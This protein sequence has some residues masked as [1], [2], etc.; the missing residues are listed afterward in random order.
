MAAYDA[1]VVGSG[2]N[3]L[4]A[5]VVIAEQGH[6]VLVLEAR[7]ALGG[8]TRT[9]ELTLP[10]FRHDVCSAFHPLGVASPLFSRLP[11]EELGVRWIVPDIQLA[12]PLDDG[13]T[14]ALW[15][16]LETTCANLGPDG[17]TWRRLVR[18]IVHDWDS[19][20]A[21]VMGPVANKAIPP[22]ALLPWLLPAAAIAHRFRAGATQAL[23]AG[24]AAHGMR[25]L[26]AP[27]TAAVGVVLGGLT[28]LGGWPLVEGGSSAITAA[29]AA[30]LVS[31]GGEVR[32]DH[33]V[34]RPG[35]L[36]PSRVVLLDTHP[37]ALLDIFGDRVVPRIARR[38]IAR[39]RSGPAAFKID[40]A[41][42]APIPWSAPECARAGVVHVGGTYSE[43]VEA[44]SAVEGGRVPDRP[45]VLVGQQSLFDPSRAPAG[46]HT[47]WVY[48]HVPGG[49]NR[50][51]KD[52]VEDQI[53]RFA[54]GFRDVVLAS[55]V[56]T[57]RD[58]EAY[59]ANY[60]GGDIAT[61]AHTLR[62]M[63]GGPGSLRNPY[64]TGVPGV[65]LCSAAT[66]PG[67]GVHGMCGANAALVATSGHGRNGTPWIGKS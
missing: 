32:L 33:P 58:L 47:A 17:D 1:V 12:H 50:S 3:G 30:H 13:R 14:A 46:K 36:P 29:L 67:P 27:A 28:H 62:R 20:A 49:F 61:G 21:V 5:A 63:L 10:G 42:D 56:T 31:L 39:Y 9:E 55:R 41:L 54:P 15:M 66:P 60:V 52:K 44:G 40:Y 51:V 35:D 25:R 19:L 8:G 6:S 59:N 64:R 24:L 7:E 22:P 48:T 38:R 11:L 18:R 4:A 2:P 65:Y 26:D 23:F 16:S 43:V 45:F 34:R 57:P 37:A 53:E